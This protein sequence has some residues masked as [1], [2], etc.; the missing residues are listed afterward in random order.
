MRRCTGEMTESVRTIDDLPVM[1]DF[2]DPEWGLRFETIVHRAFANRAAGMMR[3][4]RGDL[5]AFR[6]ADLDQLRVHPAVSH[7]TLESQVSRFPAGRDWPGLTRFFSSSTFNLRSPHHRAPKQTIGH[8][9]SPRAAGQLR[10]HLAVVVRDVLDDARSRDELEF[11]EDVAVPVVAGFWSRVLGA[12]VEESRALARD[13][14]E[15]MNVFLRRPR[16]E[17]WEDAEDAASRYMN[18]LVETLGR[19]ARDGSC[20]FASDFHEQFERHVEGGPWTDPYELLAAGIFDGFHALGAMLTFS[21]VSLV[22]ADV[23]PGRHRSEPTFAHE[24]FLEA[25]RLHS[26][27]PMVTR[28]ATE[29]FE[30][31]GSLIPEGTDIHMLWIFGNRDPDVFEEP[32]EFRLDR[33]NRPRQLS[34]GGGPYICAGRNVVRVVCEE[35]FHHMAEMRLRCEPTGPILWHSNATHAVK[36]VPVRVVE[37]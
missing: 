6:H 15:M 35:L 12:T 21:A 26:P 9:M 2:D 22:E 14:T 33:P 10:E 18:T 36:R 4:S 37:D 11:T 3:T 8:V 20:A 25:S 16:P 28:Q 24:A 32:D 5:V 31:A 7:Q 19:G 29:S 27:V 1:S 13:A 17:Q 34:F 23:R 30:H